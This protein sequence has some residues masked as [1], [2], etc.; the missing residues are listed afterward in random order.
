MLPAVTLIR[1]PQNLVLVGHQCEYLLARASTM[2]C[3]GV[4]SVR[5]FDGE[6][7]RLT[8]SKPINFSSPAKHIADVV[9]GGPSQRERCKPNFVLAETRRS[10][11]TEFMQGNDDHS[12]APRLVPR[13]HATTLW[14]QVGRVLS[15]NVS[16][17]DNRS[18]CPPF[19]NVTDAFL[20]P[21]RVKA[22]SGPMR[23]QSVCSS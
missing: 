13:S 14:A 4:R 19:R 9:L 17:H 22:A 11:L 21:S 5:H 12:C 8:V 15:M 7:A 6:G 2:R 3:H 18:R 1:G 23:T 20:G 16:Y 10:S